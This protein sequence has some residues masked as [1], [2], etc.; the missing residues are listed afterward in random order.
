MKGRQIPCPQEGSY[1]IRDL[2]GRP[3]G[4]DTRDLVYLSF[5]PSFHD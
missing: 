5:S 3:L 4:S 1:R 2:D